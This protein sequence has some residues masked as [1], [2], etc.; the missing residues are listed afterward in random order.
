[1]SEWIPIKQKMPPIGILIEI[2]ADYDDECHQGRAIY[3]LHDIDERTEAYAWTIKEGYDCTYRPT[4]WRHIDH[5]VPSD[6]KVE[7]TPTT[8]SLEPTI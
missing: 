2:K 8:N 4:H 1:M 6:K 5:I 7:D 3:N